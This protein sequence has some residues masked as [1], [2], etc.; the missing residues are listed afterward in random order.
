MSERMLTCGE[1]AKICRVKKITVYDWI[2]KGKLPAVKVGKSYLVYE[3]ELEKA[4]WA[5]E[6]WG[7]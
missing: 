4:M 7:K 5:R 3:S 2:R 1:V 6:K